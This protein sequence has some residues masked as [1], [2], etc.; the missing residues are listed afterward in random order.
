MLAIKEYEMN[1]LVHPFGKYIFR[2]TA[3]HNNRIR[4]QALDQFCQSL[5]EILTIDMILYTTIC[6]YC[7]GFFL[8][9]PFEAKHICTLIAKAHIW[10]QLYIIILHP[11]R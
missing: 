2:R 5:A 7:N 3:I 10:N 8:F 1:P 4:R 11:C 9:N 6:S